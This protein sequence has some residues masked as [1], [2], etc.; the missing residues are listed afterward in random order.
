MLRAKLLFFE[1][2][3]KRKWASS[4]PGSVVK[5]ERSP[6]SVLM[7]RGKFG[8]LSEWFRPACPPCRGPVA[9]GYDGRM[10][11]LCVHD[12]FEEF[13]EERW[14]SYPPHVIFLCFRN[15]FLSHK[16]RGEEKK[17]DNDGE[18]WNWREKKNKL[19]HNGE[20]EEVCVCRCV[21]SA[22]VHMLI[23]Q[24]EDDDTQQAKINR[25][26]L[27]WHSSAWWSH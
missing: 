3:W 19:R 15:H 4:P 23:S 6:H 1:S 11:A 9:T 13:P 24:I 2:F 10:E 16:E 20:W 12:S 25:N 14:Q 7:S 18:P 17:S 8:N 27:R 26:P 5:E 22:C 21:F